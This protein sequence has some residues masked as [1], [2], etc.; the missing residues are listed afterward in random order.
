M[1]RDTLPD[2]TLTQ[3]FSYQSQFK[4]AQVTKP[5]MD[6]FGVMGAGCTGKVIALY[7]R[8]PQSAKT[9]VSG[10]TGAR[11]AA[12]NDEQIKRLIGEAGEITAH[13]ILGKRRPK[14][15]SSDHIVNRMRSTRAGGCSEKVLDEEERKRG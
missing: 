3:R 15:V 9:C 12:A 4:V 1:G 11:R 6:K 10:N 5:A 7:E 8:N 2:A 14:L 13:G